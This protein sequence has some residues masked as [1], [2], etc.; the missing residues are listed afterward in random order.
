MP[1]NQAKIHENYK[2]FFEIGCFPTVIGTIDC[3]HIKIAGQ[4]GPAGEIFRNRKQ[5]FS[6]NVQ[7]VSSYDLK[8]QDIV[9]RWPGSTH[10]SFI[11]DKSRIKMRFEAGEFGKSVLLGDGGYKLRTF[12]MTPYRNPVSIEEE[13][14][15]KTQILVRNTVERQYGVWKRRFPCLVFGLRCK[16]QTSF[17][18]IVACAVLH[19]ICIEHKDPEPPLESDTNNEII[20]QALAGS[21]RITAESSNVHRAA[22]IRRNFFAEKITLLH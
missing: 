10:D 11:F 6:L 4:G 22:I 14:F 21:E 18:V 19:N 5:F 9:A 7:S 12:L 13:T 17:P 16:L 8:F 3:T 20:A 1:R 15:N 2:N